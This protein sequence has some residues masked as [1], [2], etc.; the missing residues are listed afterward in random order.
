MTKFTKLIGNSNRHLIAESWLGS[1][2]G[3]AAGASVAL[4]FGM[5][6]GR[7]LETIFLMVISGAVVFGGAAFVITYLHYLGRDN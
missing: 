3:M 6:T 7:S 5:M 2:F 1:L 4:M